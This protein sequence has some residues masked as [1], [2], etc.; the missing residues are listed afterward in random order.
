MAN[1]NDR[2]GTENGVALTWSV[3][4]LISVVWWVVAGQGSWQRTVLLMWLSLASFMAGTVLG[5]LFSSYGEEEGSLGKIRDWLVGLITALTVVKAAVLK[6][7]L[8]YFTMGP[9]PIEFAYA[10][11]AAVVYVAMGFFF[12]FFARGLF[13]NVSLARG[14]QERDAL[15]KAE[16]KTAE[17]VQAA[18]VRL[19]AS[20]LSGVSSL[21]DVPELA[22]KEREDLTKALSDASVDEFLKYADNAAA[23]GSLDW[24]MVFKAANI[25]YYRTYL[26]DDNEAEVKTAIDWI[27]RALNMNPKH[28][29][30]TLKYADMLGAKEDYSSAVAVLERLAPL[31]EAPAIVKQWL[32]Y[33][34]RFMPNRL[35]ESIRLSTEYHAMF[36]NETDAAFSI[37]WA[38]AAKHGVAV[39]AGN[40]EGAGEYRRKALDTLKDALFAV[41]GMKDRIR[42]KWTKKGAAFGGL[43]GDPEFAALVSA[44]AA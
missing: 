12:M 14:R 40:K 22:A 19:P 34:L 6:D 33:Y 44:T 21:D 26:R 5:F 1:G 32:G 36:P 35:D 29:D 9:D 25:H 38:Y 3:F 23:N 11:G 18:I 17:I 37:A 13:L 30:L 31:P 39:D 10:L 16:G 41:P 15:A 2:K 20:Y 28:I 24:D 4:G 8:H 27:V 7:A 42:D 43:A